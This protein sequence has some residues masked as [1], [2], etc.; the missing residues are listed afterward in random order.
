MAVGCWRSPCFLPRSSSTVCN[1]SPTLSLLSGS[2]QW[3]CMMRSG[4]IDI[5]Y[6]THRLPYKH[7]QV[8]CSLF[9]ISRAP[10]SM[11]RRLIES[12]IKIVSEECRGRFDKVENECLVKLMMFLTS[13]ELTPDTGVE[14]NIN[15]FYGVFSTVLRWNMCYVSAKYMR[16]SSMAKK[17]QKPWLH[18]VC[19]L[20][21]FM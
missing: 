5:V 19:G 3:I 6:H 17:H 2:Y 14:A 10:H 20:W 4:T 15:R 18:C 7:I 11:R 16:S 9:E 12:F 1:A 21:S 8:T 13:M